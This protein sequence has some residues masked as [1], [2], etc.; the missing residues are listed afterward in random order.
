MEHKAQK[1]LSSGKGVLL[2][3]ESMTIFR[4]YAGVINRVGVS[5]ILA[6]CDVANLR[7]E[8]YASLEKRIVR[9]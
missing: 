1:D 2:K 4:E 8:K 3:D 9:Y 6:H 5:A 7:R